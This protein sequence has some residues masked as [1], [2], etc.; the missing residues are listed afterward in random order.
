MIRL[1]GLTKL[2]KCLQNMLKALSSTPSA[3]HS[4]SG[5]TILL[6]QHLKGTGE[7]LRVQGYHQPRSR[8]EGSMGFMRP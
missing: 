3:I 2:L 6:S 8:L 5:D 7:G 4:R 1:G